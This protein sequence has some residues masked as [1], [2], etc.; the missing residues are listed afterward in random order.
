MSWSAVKGVIGYSALGLWSAEAICSVF[1]HAIKNC[2]KGKKKIYCAEL[3]FNWKFAW[4]QQKHSELTP[5]SSSRLVYDSGG[6]AAEGGD[7]GHRGPRDRGDPAVWDAS[8]SGQPDH[9][10][11]K[12]KERGIR[13]PSV[14]LRYC[15]SAWD[16]PVTVLSGNWTHFDLGSSRS[17]TWWTRDFWSRPLKTT[18]NKFVM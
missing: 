2:S 11:L 7:P 16:R 10:P 18:M 4:T 8:A 15:C 17:R 6:L 1:M 3:N 12:G 13:C 9:L 14:D 5:L